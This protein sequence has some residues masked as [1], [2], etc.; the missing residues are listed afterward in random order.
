M[1]RREGAGRL[2]L[3]FLTGAAGGFVGIA[4]TSWLADGPKILGAS[5]WEVMTAFG[6]V[7]AVVVALLIPI[8]QYWKRQQEVAVNRWL[9]SEAIVDGLLDVLVDCATVSTYLVT[10]I[11]KSGEF[12]AIHNLSDQ[13]ED[14]RAR[15]RNLRQAAAHNYE[16]RLLDQLGY[17][18]ANLEQCNS[19]SGRFSASEKD[20]FHL[21]VAAVLER[22]QYVGGTAKKIKQKIKGKL[23]AAGM[24]NLMWAPIDSQDDDS[25]YV[26]KLLERL[27]KDIAYFDKLIG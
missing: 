8:W 17:T 9:A 24:D 25:D 1:S 4:V 23:E 3:V 2:A 22:L 19:D 21:E 14:C 20:L 7:G 5:W 12:W 10:E 15:V 13:L 16:K 11:V 26:E 18:I 6:T 27:K